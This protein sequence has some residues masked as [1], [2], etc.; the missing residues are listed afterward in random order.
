MEGT[1]FNTLINSYNLLEIPKD[2]TDMSIIKRAF[3]D[4]SSNVHD[5]QSIKKLKDA[6]LYVKSCVQ[7]Q[8]ELNEEVNKAQDESNTDFTRF[9]NPFENRETRER[10]NRP[11]IDFSL[12]LKCDNSIIGD[13]FDVD[14]VYQETI[15]NRS[16]TTNYQNIKQ[17]ESDNPLRNEKFCSSKFNSLFEDNKKKQEQ[18]INNLNQDYNLECFGGFDELGGAANVISDGAYL[19]VNGMAS[20]NSNDLYGYLP[21]ADPSF[22]RMPSDILV[23]ES[24]LTKYTDVIKNCA[25]TYNKPTSKEFSEQMQNMCTEQI[26]IFEDHTNRNKKVIEEYMKDLSCE[27]RSKLMNFK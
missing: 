17:P 14:Q 15:K 20:E 21:A 7:Y 11:K 1:K 22:E 18:N 27:T 3:L 5:L 19:F 24:D 4:K 10:P 26:K 2:C 9:S 25:P 12:Q 6:Y 16:T 8:S 13:N 23:T